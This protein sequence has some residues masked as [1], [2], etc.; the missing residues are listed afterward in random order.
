MVQTPVRQITLEEFLALPDTK[1][2]SEYTALSL[3]MKYGEPLLSQSS[4]N[5][6]VLHIAGKCCNVSIDSHLAPV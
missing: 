2:A 3:F 4:N 1:P 5:V 6:C